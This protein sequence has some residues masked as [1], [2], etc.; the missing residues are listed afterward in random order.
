M[1][2]CMRADKGGQL[3]CRVPART[4]ALLSILSQQLPHCN[5]TPNLSQPIPA[6]MCLL[7]S[8]SLPRSNLWHARD[9]SRKKT[10]FLIQI[11]KS[12]VLS[13]T[14]QKGRG[15]QRLGCTD[16]VK[17]ASRRE[18]G[19]SGR[20]DFCSLLCLP[21]ELIKQAL[22]VLIQQSEQ[23]TITGPKEGKTEEAEKLGW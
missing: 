14:T 16:I 22:Q 21:M 3:V 19:A 15:G 4:A 23:E 10:L 17:Q 13:H 18:V 9:F 5:N 12:K 8:L 6:K 20:E 2:V 11:N 1:C 7:G